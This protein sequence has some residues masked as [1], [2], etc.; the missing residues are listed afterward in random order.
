MLWNLTS[1]RRLNVYVSPSSEISHESASS[2]TRSLRAYGS[3]SHPLYTPIT[4]LYIMLTAVMV[5]PAAAMAGSSGPGSNVKR[6]VI[7][8]PNFGG[9]SGSG[10]W[11]GTK[12]P[13]SVVK[14]SARLIVATVSSSSTSSSVTAT[15]APPSSSS[16]SALVCCVAACCV[17]AGA[18]VAWAAGA[19]SSSSSSPPQPISAAAARPTPPSSPPR[20]S[21]RRVTEYPNNRVPFASMSS[22]MSVPPGKGHA[23]PSPGLY[24]RYVSGCQRVFCRGRRGT[25]SPLAAS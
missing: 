8:P 23:T 24:R 19:S 18:A 11:N 10:I 17:A 3:E 21:V 9:V 4:R 12:R 20:S 6:C 2:G 1:P 22:G 25:A 16:S 7:V 5:P 13:A 14:P 15:C